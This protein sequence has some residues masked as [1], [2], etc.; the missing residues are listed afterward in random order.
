MFT[1]GPLAILFLERRNRGHAA[2]ICFAA[3][4]AKKGTHQQGGVEPI[5][6]GPAMVPLDRDAG[7]M[8]HE[9]FDAARPQP[10]RQPE[11]VTTCFEGNGNA[12]DRMSRSD[13]LIT[14][15]AEPNEQCFR[16]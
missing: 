13:G 16:V 15:A 9:C 8:D 2:V 10:A 1:V 4:P 5:G 11:A 7:W 6:L 12:R 3:Q 14:P